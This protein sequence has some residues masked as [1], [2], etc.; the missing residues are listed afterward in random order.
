V[1]FT[2]ESKNRMVLRLSYKCFKQECPRR[3]QWNMGIK[4]SIRALVEGEKK[5]NEISNEKRGGLENKDSMTG[6]KKDPRW[7][8]KVL[9]KGN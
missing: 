6:E 3:G 2:R 8:P 4:N 9:K 5:E 7:Q 1:G